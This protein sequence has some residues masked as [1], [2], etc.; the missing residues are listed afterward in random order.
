VPDHLADPADL[1]YAEEHLSD[2]EA[3]TAELVTAKPHL[4]SRRPVGDV[5]QGV[6][7]MANSQVDLLGLLRSRA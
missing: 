6:K 1:E 2:P 5:G 7:G 3:L 4:K